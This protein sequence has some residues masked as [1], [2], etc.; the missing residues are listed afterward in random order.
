[1]AD[2][3]VGK[4]LNPG[5]SCREPHLSIVMQQCEDTAAEGVSGPEVKI[6]VVQRET[7]YS[8]MDKVDPPQAFLLLSL[9][10]TRPSN[11]RDSFS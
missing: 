2:I 10:L 7:L 3:S 1:M 5:L 9:F 4:I 11:L 8:S 6:S